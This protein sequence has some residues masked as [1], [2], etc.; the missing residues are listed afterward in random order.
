[1]GD[2]KVQ[3]QRHRTRHIR[4]ITS[5]FDVPTSLTP[6]ASHLLRFHFVDCAEE[7][8]KL[9]NR[10]VVSLLGVVGTSAEVDPQRINLKLPATASRER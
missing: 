9:I 6:A 1:M 3:H 7:V 8:S 5:Q 10:P 2:A 4:E